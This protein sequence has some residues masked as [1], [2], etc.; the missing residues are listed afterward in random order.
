VN[1]AEADPILT[2]LAQTTGTSGAAPA[3]AWTTISRL[4]Q[5]VL[6]FGSSIVLARLLLPS[7]YGLIAVVGS[8]MVFA[9]LFTD[10]GLGAAIIH[11]D[12]PTPSFLSTVFWVNAVTG[13][14]LSLLSGALGY[15]LAFIYG[16][17]QLRDLMWIGGL[18]FALDVRIVHTSLLERTM[19]FRQL[20]LVETASTFIGIATSTTA[21]AVFHAGA[22]SLVLGPVFATVAASLLLWLTVPWRPS[23]T[24]TR[25]DASA[26]IRFGRGLLGFNILTYWSRNADNVLLAGVTSATQLGLYSRAYALMMGPLTQV[27]NVFGRVLFP[28]FTRS[29]DNPREVGR[30]WLRSTKLIFLTTAPIALLLSTAA[31]AAIATFYGPHWRG[32]AIMLELLAA[33]AT[34]QLLPVASGQV[35]YAFG[36][37]DELFR[38]G[39]VSSTCT[40]VAIGAGLPWGAV[41]VAAGI[42]VNTLLMSWYPVAGV[43]RLTEMRLADALASLKGLLLSAVA[44]AAV[45]IAV[46]LLLTAVV[47]DAVLLLLQ[48]A[49]GF[50]AMLVALSVLD[51]LLFDDARRYAIRFGKR[52][53]GAISGG[54]RKP[55]SPSR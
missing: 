40:V 19:R 38:R 13:V 42:L 4:V 34:L 39:L 35:Y 44:F 30:L 1:A 14:G 16:E 22:T 6:Q 7:D 28:I 5:Q 25:Q 8:V 23:L 3:L 12:I 50:V 52:L 43:C 41:G 21:A 33:A 54:R 27:S 18:T 49:A 53:L 48:G 46:R 10:L 26:T 55:R 20:A 11:R 17:H 24:A 2:R 32:A 45:S 29:R 15:L 9:Q 47:P 31:P 36:A 37:T 51:H